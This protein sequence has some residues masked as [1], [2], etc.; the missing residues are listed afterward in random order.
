MGGKVPYSYYL[1]NSAPVVKDYMETMNIIAGAGGCKKLKYKVD[2]E[3]SILRYKHFQ[4]K[5]EY[6]TLT[7]FDI[8]LRWE[9]M[10]EGGDIG[11][12]IYYKSAEEGTVDLVSLS[13]IESHLV[14][15]EGE[16]TCTNPGKCTNN[17]TTQLFL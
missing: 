12:K 9:F 13:R 2:V 8:I 5:F 4:E 6:K 10:T 15:E 11:F 17:I 14:M 7:P 3:N 1:S 16:L